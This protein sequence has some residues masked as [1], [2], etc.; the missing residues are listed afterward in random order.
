MLANYEQLLQTLIQE[1]PWIGSLKWPMLIAHTA[2]Q[3]TDITCHTVNL[4]ALTQPTW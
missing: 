4:Y 3:T 1:P 2:I